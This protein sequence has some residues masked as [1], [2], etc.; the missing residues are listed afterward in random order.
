[1]EQEVKE[2]KKLV[3]AATEAGDHEKKEEAIA[4]LAAAEARVDQRRHAL[5]AAEDATKEEAELVNAKFADEEEK[6]KEKEAAA[7]AAA[8][9]ARKNAK[10]KDDSAGVLGSV[11]S[12]G[13]LFGDDKPDAKAAEEDAEP[14]ELTP[15]QRSAKEAE[16]AS[17]S[18]KWALSAADSAEAEA[19][20][21]YESSGKPYPRTLK[22]AEKELEVARQAVA[23]AKP[24][25]RNHAA[26]ELA[27]AQQ[28]VDL[29]RKAEAIRTVATNEVVLARNA[30]AVVRA[31]ERAVAEAKAAEEAK[32]KRMIEAEEEAVKY[33]QSFGPKYENMEVFELKVELKRHKLS[34]EGT[35]LQLM[36]RLC[37]YLDKE[38]RH[39]LPT[40]ITSVVPVPSPHSVGIGGAKKKNEKYGGMEKAELKAE[41]EKRGLDTKGN[42]DAMEVRLTKNDRQEMKKQLEEKAQEFHVPEGVPPGGKKKTKTGGAEGDEAD[43]DGGVPTLDDPLA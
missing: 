2:Y 34:E 28:R 19:Q 29:R 9:E 35:K 21:M 41:L 33:L 37:T 7:A 42:K 36:E 14:T 26:V 16:E 8:A 13:G 27:Q 15:I 3:E 4:E 38:P 31:E 32:Q 24:A 11:M 6:A 39:L 25:E 5:A 30:T 22:K 1:M 18:A 17:V 20:E 43:E 23:R 12:M 40:A 10:G